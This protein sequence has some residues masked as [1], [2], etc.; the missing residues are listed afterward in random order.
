MSLL[1]TTPVSVYLRDSLPLCVTLTVADGI[2]L[3]V[4]HSWASAGDAGS[5]RFVK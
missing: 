2:R 1:T 4:A 5:I 3:P